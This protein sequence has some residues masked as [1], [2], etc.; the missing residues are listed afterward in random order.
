MTDAEW[1]TSTD[2]L[3][4]F[5]HLRGSPKRLSRWFPW[6]TSPPPELDERK[7]RLFLVVWCRERHPR[8]DLFPPGEERERVLLAL[9]TVDDLTAG[10]RALFLA[11]LEIEELSV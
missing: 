4:M 2:A 3:R 6:A 5:T 8:M 7:M 11:R 9:E 10:G 1:R